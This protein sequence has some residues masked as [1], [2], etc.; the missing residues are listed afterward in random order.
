MDPLGNLTG[1][2]GPARPTRTHPVIYPLNLPVRGTAYNQRV[3]NQIKFTYASIRF[4]VEKKNTQNMQSTLSWKAFL[5]WKKDGDTNLT[6]PDLFQ[7]DANGA[8]TPMCYTNHETF[9]QFYRPKYLTKHGKF[10]DE[11]GGNNHGFFAYNYPRMSQKLSVQT[12]FELG[13]DSVCT[14]MRP[15]LVFMSDDN[16]VHPTDTDHVDFTG[17]VRLSYVDN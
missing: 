4:Q 11:T 16:Q 15:Y 3:G 1:M 13:S 5:V 9:K 12:K 8:Y 7:T 17:T 2:Y 10:I 6:M 14:Q